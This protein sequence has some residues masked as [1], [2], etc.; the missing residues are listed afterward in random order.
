MIELHLSKKLTKEDVFHEV[1][2]FIENHGLNIV[3]K[4]FDR[5]WG[6]FFVLEESQIQ[7]FRDLFFADVELTEQQ[8]TQ[9]LSPKFLIVA[10]GQRLSWQY[11]FRRAEL[12][13]LIAGESGIARSA[14][15]EQGEV[16]QMVL[17]QTVSLQKGERH[18]LI[19]LE[20]WGVVAEI[21]MHS[22]P[23][24]PSDEADIVR[25]QDDY[26]RK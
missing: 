10:P 16:L 13:K 5:P 11:H 17:G 21:W 7:K 24:N 18:R 22:D 3:Q 19:G 9:K 12:W 25:L 8:Y 15:D 1:G 2:Q 20:N 4:D 14:S 26:S 6:G 23:E